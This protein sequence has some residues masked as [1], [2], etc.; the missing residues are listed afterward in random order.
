[1]GDAVIA[2]A[3]CVRNLGVIFDTN[4]SMAT[5]VATVCKS[6]RFHLRSTGK[7]RRHLTPDVC[8]SIHVLVDCRLDI[9][10]ALSSLLHGLRQ[11]LLDQLRRCLNVASRIVICQKKSCHITPILRNLHWL[12]VNYRVGFKVLLH[13]YRALSSSLRHT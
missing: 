9:N 7:I 3:G 8:E 13:M 12:P 2:P 6:L 1:M 10:G 11:C 5:H 4:I